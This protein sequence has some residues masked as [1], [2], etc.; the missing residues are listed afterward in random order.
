MIEEMKG[1]ALNMRRVRVGA[2]CIL[3]AL[4]SVISIYNDLHFF[5]FEAYSSATIFYGIIKIIFIVLVWLLIWY[6]VAIVTAWSG[7]F[8]GIIMSRERAKA[9][10]TFFVLLL[11][12]Y[13]VFFILLYP[14]EW[15]LV[16]DEFLVYNAAVDLRIWGNQ[17]T[18]S[19]IF[20]ILGLMVFPKPAMVIAVQCLITAL[21]EAG[22]LADTWLETLGGKKRSFALLMLFLSIPCIA[23]S[24]CPVRVWIFSLLILKFMACLLKI[25]KKEGEVSWQEWVLLTVLCCLIVNCREEGKLLILFFPLLLWKRGCGKSLKWKVILGEGIVVLSILFFA[26]LT[27]LGEGKTLRQHAM[28][29]FICPLS[30]MLS[31]E[32]IYDKIPLEDL[33]NI[34]NVF[35]IEVLRK[36]PSYTE[37]FQWKAGEGMFNEPSQ[38]ELRAG[39]WSAVKLCLQYPQI[40]FQCKLQAAS[41]SLGLPPWPNVIGEVWDAEKLE[42]WVKGMGYLPERFQCFSDVSKYRETWSRILSGKFT[43]GENKGYYFVYAF[44]V[45]VILLLSGIWTCRGKRVWL[46][47]LWLASQFLCTVLMAP[48]R[49]NMYYLP[50]Y[51]CGWFLVISRVETR[52]EGCRS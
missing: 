4:I 13:G 27:N 19:S 26:L 44:W 29:N 30:I 9:L 16:G 49:Y 43:E 5:N 36:Y 35:P 52:N 51:L 46:L 38:K 37:M 25:W 15:G 45:P 47:Y 18:F 12:V 14:G 20:M 11:S 2:I 39:I 1:T 28:V 33:E 21:V 7:H 50:Y 24:M 8:G 10:L 48:S 41:W 23:F 17:G 6:I 22:I 31:E 32:E 42:T 3:T 40:Y 34:D